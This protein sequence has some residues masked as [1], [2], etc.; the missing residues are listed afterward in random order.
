M[1][2][3]PLVLRRLC[4]L[5]TL[6]SFLYLNK[7][8]ELGGRSWDLAWRSAFR[9]LNRHTLNHDLYESIMRSM[10]AQSHCMEMSSFEMV[11]V[12]GYERFLAPPTAC[13]D[14]QIWLERAMVLRLATT[15]VLP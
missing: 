15:S 3:P 2:G 4:H 11:Q 1:S 14:S 6:L 10:I 7:V 12:K 9:G 13:P 8:E 5:W